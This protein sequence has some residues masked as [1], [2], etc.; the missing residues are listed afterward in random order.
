[1]RIL[2]SLNKEKIIV[3]WQ[4]FKPETYIA[5]F[6]VAQAIVDPMMLNR[7]GQ[8]FVNCKGCRQQLQNQYGSELF[9]FQG[10]NI[11]LSMWFPL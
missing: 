11:I 7:E 1:M 4:L 10:Q 3:Y 5:E 8:S 6:K 2:L 9:L